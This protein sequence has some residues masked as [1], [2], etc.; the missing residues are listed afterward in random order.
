[1]DIDLHE[2][3]EDLIT[4]AARVVRWAPKTG[5]GLSLAA[6]RILARLSDNGPSRIG[7]LAAQERSSQPTITNHVKR[8]EAAGLVARR[9][10]PTD[11]R[12][13][14]IDLT[15]AGRQELASMRS[16]LG[17]NVE[18]YLAKLPESD[19]TALRAGIEAMRRLMTV[20][21]LPQ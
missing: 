12:A 6:A 14:M 2:L 16:S 5:F 20:D 9:V 1:M 13:W 17:T 7:D 10:D 8:L 18:P 11:A 4:T 15:E 3:G 21:R 19:L